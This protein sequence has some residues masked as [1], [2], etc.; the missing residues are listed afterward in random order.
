[1]KLKVGIKIVTSTIALSLVLIATCSFAQEND[2]INLSFNL[3]KHSLDKGKVEFEN[4]GIDFYIQ[5]SVFSFDP[6]EDYSVLDISIIDRLEIVDFNQFSDIASMKTK[7]LNINNVKKGYVN[8]IPNN[9]I[10][11]CILLYEN[12]DD[13]IYRYPVTWTNAH[14]D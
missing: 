13:K 5:N 12:K 4:G 2:T 8:I 9:K 10:F 3:E 6:T 7:E 14:T 11:K 1:M